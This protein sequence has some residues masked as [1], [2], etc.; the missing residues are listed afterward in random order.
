MFPLPRG[1]T[2]RLGGAGL[3]APKPG[4]P[5]KQLPGVKPC[6]LPAPH[7]HPAFQRLQ[8]RNSRTPGPRTHVLLWKSRA[9]T[10]CKVWRYF[11]S[12]SLPITKKKT[13]LFLLSAKIPPPRSLRSHA[14]TAVGTTGTLDRAGRS[15]ADG[16]GCRP[17]GIAQPRP[18]PGGREGCRTVPRGPS[19]R[20]DP[21][22]AG[23]GSSLPDGGRF[24]L[25]R[26]T[27]RLNISAGARVWK[28]VQLG[29]RLLSRRKA[30]RRTRRRGG[31]GSA[32]PRRGWPPP[33]RPS[34]LTPRGAL[35]APCPPAHPEGASGSRPGVPGRARAGQGGAR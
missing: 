6:L 19:G 14:P 31:A 33:R 35:H 16:R 10:K 11:A 17:G 5:G 27:A 24:L 20:L 26:L 1:P 9:R 18:S 34:D 23:P 25:R 13:A 12:P 28:V 7:R 30:R 22:P 15:G 2:L 21:Q 32:P 3:K 8:R 4:C 29:A